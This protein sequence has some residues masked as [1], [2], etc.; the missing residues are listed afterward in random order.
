[1]NAGSGSLKLQHLLNKTFNQEQLFPVVGPGSSSSQSQLSQT[2][3]HFST[4]VSQTEKKFS[5][6]TYSLKFYPSCLGCNYFQNVFW[7]A[8]SSKMSNTTFESISEQCVKQEH[9]GTHFKLLSLVHN[10]NVIKKRG[11]HFLIYWFKK[12]WC[13]VTGC[14]CFNKAVVKSDWMKHSIHAAETS[15]WIW[16]HKLHLNQFGQHQGQKASHCCC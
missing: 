14:F 13:R 6:N 11:L 12:G 2:D 8:K 15:G 10:L 1:M 9:T 16:Q 4:C 5:V 3:K 7:T